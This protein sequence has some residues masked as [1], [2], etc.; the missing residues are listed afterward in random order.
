MNAYQA[1]QLEAYDAAV[2]Y[3]AGLERAQR[4]SLKQLIGDYLLFR[5]RAANFLHRHFQEICTT[6]CYQNQRSACCTK[7]GILVFFADVL[8]NTLVSTD[9]EIQS[10]MEILRQPNPGS[11]CVYLGP[12]GCRWKLKPKVC[13]LFLCDRAEELAFLTNPVAK[14]AW[15]EIRKTEKRY[16]W[17]DRPVL[18]ESLEAMVMAQGLRSSLMHMHNSPGL[19]MVRMRAGRKEI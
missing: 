12:A 11:K 19:R 3:L 18:F 4:M 2:D 9:E 10:L 7:D 16:T 6:Q 8:I 5:E 14:K 13:E 15:E 17:P 1:E